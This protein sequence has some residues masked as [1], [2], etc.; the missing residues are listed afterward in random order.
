MVFLM[1]RD[2]EK[3][4]LHPWTIQLIRETRATGVRSIRK[5]CNE[6]ATLLEREKITD[7]LNYIWSQQLYVTE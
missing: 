5:Q 4:E 1:K 7:Q 6:E 3:M 2:P